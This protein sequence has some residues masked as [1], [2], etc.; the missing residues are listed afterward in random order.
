MISSTTAST[1]L[2]EGKPYLFYGHGA[3]NALKIKIMFEELG[4][5]YKFVDVDIFNDASESKVSF[6]K[7]FPNGKVPA[8]VDYTVSPPLHIFESGAILLYLAAKHGRFLPDIKSH[9][10]QHADVLQW[11]AWQISGLG[12][13]NGQF[14]YFAVFAPEA[15]PAAQERYYKETDRLYSVLDQQLKDKEWIAGGQYSIADMA[16]YPW[17][18]YI[19]EGLLPHS[20]KYPNVLAWLDRMNKRP[21]VAKELPGI[22]APLPGYI[23][24]LKSKGT[25]RITQ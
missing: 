24:H 8:I 10:A 15:V 22:L 25:Y 23:A 11:L 17:A 3:T 5:D 2:N 19:R 16:V 7:I 12:P 1:Q 21:V 13:M 4:L 6:K 14:T 20:E 9:P 18:V